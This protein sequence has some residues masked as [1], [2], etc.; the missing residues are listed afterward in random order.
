MGEGERCL[1]LVL[2]AHGGVKAEKLKVALSSVSDC[3][4]TQFASEKVRI[5]CVVALVLTVG[6]ASAFPGSSSQIIH[7][8][9]IFQGLK[10]GIRARNKCRVVP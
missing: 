7:C 5:Q 3:S 4:I 10:E 2:K 9:C 1:V 8:S 6:Y